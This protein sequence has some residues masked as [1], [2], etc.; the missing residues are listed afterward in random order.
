[1]LAARALIVGP[2]RRS[3]SIGIVSSRRPDDIPAFN[4][5]MIEEFAEG[6]HGGAGPRDGGYASL[7]A[8]AFNLL[9]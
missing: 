4:R 3:S 8:H 1:M 9:R 6:V 7:T 2:S 5:K